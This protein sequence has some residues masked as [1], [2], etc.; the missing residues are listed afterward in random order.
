MIGARPAS[1]V[2][3]VPTKACQATV[4]VS[5]QTELQIRQRY[6]QLLARALI[7]YTL[8]SSIILYLYAHECMFDN[9]AALTLFRP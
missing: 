6:S 9:I 4:F 5:K 2:V 7:V 3:M 8:I 1:S